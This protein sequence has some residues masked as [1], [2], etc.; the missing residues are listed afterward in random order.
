MLY[1]LFVVGVVAFSFLPRHFQIITVY[2]LYSSKSKTGIIDLIWNE[3]TSLLF[4][5]IKIIIHTIIAVSS[6][7]YIQVF[8]S[9][10]TSISLL[11]LFF[12]L[13]FAWTFSNLK[14]MLMMMIDHSLRWVS[15][16]LIDTLFLDI[17]KMSNKTDQMTKQLPQINDRTKYARKV[18]RNELTLLTFVF[19]WIIYRIN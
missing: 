6:C 15:F 3:L 11:F 18:K 14:M 10:C 4:F 17:I 16:C 8:R 9:R 13:S 5:I 2:L 12:F 1:F 7:F 19:R